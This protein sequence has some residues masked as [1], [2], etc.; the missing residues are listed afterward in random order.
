MNTASI[1]IVDDDAGLRQL[2]CMT[3]KFVGLDVREAG[4]GLDALAQI[5][6]DLPDLVL[7]DVVMP[8]MDGLT[9]CRTLRADPATEHLP[10]IM[11]SGK[12][13]PR[14]IRQCLDSGA[15]EYITKPFV[16]KEL[17]GRIKALLNG[18]RCQETMLVTDQG[19]VGVR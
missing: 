9:L 10:V 15:D 1:L 12:S 3:L 7:L 11:I 5:R 4:D 19:R 16:I 13:D 8:K 17:T 6:A 2:L 14:L 18:R